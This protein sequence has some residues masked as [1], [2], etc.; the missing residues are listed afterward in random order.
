MPIGVT[1]YFNAICAD[2]DSVLVGFG[3]ENIEGFVIRRIGIEL[4]YLA[5]TNDECM[6][7]RPSPPPRSHPD[8]KDIRRVA[9]KARVS[10]ATVSR[11]A[12]GLGS[13]DKRLA[14]RVWEAIREVGYVP[15]AQARALVSGRSRT[16]GL[17]VSEITN[18]FFS[19]LIE[20]FEDIACENDFEVMIGSTDHNP[21]RAKLFVKRLAHRKVE[22]VAVMSFESESHLL[23]DLIEQHIPLVTL[24]VSLNTPLSLVLELDYLEGITQAI[25]HLAALGHRRIAF[26]GGSMR[27]PTNFRRREAFTKAIISTGLPLEESWLFE[28]DLTLEGGTHAARNF[29]DAVVQPTAIVCTN[30]MMA[31]GVLRLLA[32]E[33][34]GVPGSMSVVC[35][36][37]RN[38]GSFAT[39]QLTTV[40]ICREEV[41]RSA[42]KALRSF[43][44]SETGPSYDRI[45]VSTSLVVGKSTDLRCEAGKV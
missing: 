12:N 32:Q 30:D 17:L 7:K 38:L 44:V 9:E 20:S 36:D 4:L 15:N 18:P 37:D 27:H 34:I 41:A 29:L 23:E 35:F 25:M 13:V 8:A 2:K 43:I 14:K 24:D 33:D 5:R 10:L 1:V 42:F 19:E 45:R 39:P 22:G 26:A 16:L 21:D 11:V 31:L 3:A 40:R 6:G 28:G